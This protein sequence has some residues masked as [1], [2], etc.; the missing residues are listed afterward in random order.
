MQYDGRFR[1]RSIE[2]RRFYDAPSLTLVIGV[3]VV[4]AI[5]LGLLVTGKPG[6][7]VLLGV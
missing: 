1:F 7:R 6:L 5:Q 3:A 4:I 2:P